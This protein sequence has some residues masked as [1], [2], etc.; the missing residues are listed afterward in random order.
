MNGR[1]SLNCPKCHYEFEY[2]GGKVERQIADLHAYIGDLKIEISHIKG[3][4]GTGTRYRK[5]QV[6]L[7][8]SISRLNKLR[9]YRKLA[10]DSIK[11]QRY[12]LLLE[13]IKE[14]YGETGLKKCERY[15]DECMSPVSYE[16]LAT[17]SR[18]IQAQ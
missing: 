10:G 9:D 1:I 3:I 13:A 8:R 12:T 16:D 11:N 14:L 15:V 6:E 4:A 18:D 17:S 5:L 2:N 7:A